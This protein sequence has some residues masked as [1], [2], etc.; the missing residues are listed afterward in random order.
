MNSLH[1]SPAA[2]STSPPP[3]RLTLVWDAPVRIFHWLAVLCF[4]GAYLTAEAERWRLVHVTLGYTLA[5]LVAFRLVWGFIGTRH[6]RFSDFVRGPKEALAHLRSLLAGKPDAHAGHNPAGGLA[7]LALLGL[8]IGV[9]ATGW[10]TQAEW[11]GER[12]EEAH[13]LVANLML[14]LVGVHVA[15]VLLGSRLQGENLV[16]AMITGRKK[17]PPAQGIRRAWYSVAALMLAAVLAFWWLQ[18]REVPAVGASSP[19]HGFVVQH[20]EDDDDDD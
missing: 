16:K 5:G 8:A 2:A 14:A 6:A 19:A 18:S 10:M 11:S 4:A 1:A 7:I 13:E 15:A 12:F 17:A 9:T 3:G 20:D